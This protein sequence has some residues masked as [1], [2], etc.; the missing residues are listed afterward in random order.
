M[1]MRIL[2]AA[3]AVAAAVAVTMLVAVVEVLAFN[4]LPDIAV[5]H[6]NLNPSAPP[7]ISLI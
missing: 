3:A 2:V 4:I 1:N 5:N 6:Y 7:I